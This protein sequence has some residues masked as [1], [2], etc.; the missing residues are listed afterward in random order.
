MR[1]G[2]GL[3]ASTTRWIGKDGRGEREEQEDSRIGRMIQE[4][5]DSSVLTWRSQV[6]EEMMW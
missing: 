1:H 4:T 5:E 2:W 3:H 6:T